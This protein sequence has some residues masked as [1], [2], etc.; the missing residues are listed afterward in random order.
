MAKFVVG[1]FC[2][3]GLELDSLAFRFSFGLSSSNPLLVESLSVEAAWLEGSCH[4]LMDGLV[5]D[6]S[7][8][9]VVSGSC[10]AGSVLVTGLVV[11]E[12]VVVD[13][14]ASR[15]SCL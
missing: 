9:S 4:T 2:F 10:S 12:L 11:E 1:G 14:A 13:R 6:S 3:C 15:T 8:T 7:S 5:L